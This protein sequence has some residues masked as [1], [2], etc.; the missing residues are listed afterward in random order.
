MSIK[1]YASQDW[2][3]EEIAKIDIPE[4]AQPDFSSAEVGQVIVV[5]TVDA[6]GKP[7]EWECID[8]FVLA[9]ETTGTKYRLS[10][11]DGKLVMTEVIS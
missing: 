9:D 1:V 7:T 3:K 11:S 4:Q 2:V 10:V 6:N 8:P 5:K